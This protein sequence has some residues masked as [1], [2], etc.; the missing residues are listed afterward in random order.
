MAY[1]ILSDS[2][3]AILVLSQSTN[4]S[5]PLGD[6][7]AARLLLLPFPPLDP[8]PLDPPPSPCSHD[9]TIQPD[10]TIR[11]SLDMSTA[12][13]CEKKNM[14]EGHKKKTQKKEAEAGIFEFR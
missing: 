3:F 4:Q 12:S 10:P 1:L 14:G 5:P 2:M 6:E 11:A 13:I 7:H 8:S 9:T